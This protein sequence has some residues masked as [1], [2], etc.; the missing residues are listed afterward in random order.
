[1]T[2]Q[3][4]GNVHNV[5]YAVAAPDPD[6]TEL[7]L[8]PGTRVFDR[9]TLIEVIGEG[10][11]GVVWRARDE[12][13][14][15]EV[16]LKFLPDQVRRDPES[17]RDQKRE[18]RRS[19]GLAHHNIVKVY[20]FEEDRMASAIAMEYV[21]GQSLKALKAARP[22][23]CFDVI[24]L[25]PLVR[26]VCAAL[27]YAHTQARVVHRDLKPANLLVT[28]EGWLKIVDFGIARSLRETQT[29]QTGNAQGVSGTLA[30][31]SPQ[32]LLSASKPAAADD[33]YS[34]GATLYDLL[35]GKPPFFGPDPFNEI[36]TA[37]VA[38]LEQRRAELENSGAP[39]PPHWQRTILACL[40]K[41]PEA[42][43]SNALE[44]LARLEGR[45]DRDETKIISPPFSPPRPRD[46]NSDKTIPIATTANTPPSIASHSKPGPDLSSRPFQP[47]AKL[48]PPPSHR[49]VWPSIVCFGA[50]ILFVAIFWFGHGGP[51]PVPVTAAELKAPIP[52]SVPPSSNTVTLTALT[53]LNIQVATQNPDGTR[54]EILIPNTPLGRGEQRSVPW[55]TA[56]FIT[57]TSWENLRVEINGRSIPTSFKGNERAVLP[58]PP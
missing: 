32:Q 43:P 56:L 8:Q 18:T 14:E 24:D 28:P 33:V 11:M 22:S 42:R 27:D 35:T 44:I 47:E 34:V 6:L 49:L 9:Y 53:D 21:P 45:T 46:V 2:W 23:G 54:G 1:M 19:L 4:S 52:T 50:L 37:T 40:A 36:R 31:M 58:A 20:G 13:L 7:I 16:A 41:E 12:K 39:I 55:G 57:C 29:Q 10:G 26:Q 38:P 5:G 48:P 51:T 30:F 15:H 25:L 3:L 17:V